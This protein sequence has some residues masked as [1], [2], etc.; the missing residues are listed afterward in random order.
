MSENIETVSSKN[1]LELQEPE[2][3][4][5]NGTS[6]AV[7]P[8]KLIDQVVG[9]E[10]AVEIIRKAAAQKRNVLLVGQPGTGK[11]MIAQAMAEILPLSSLK[12][13]LIYPNDADP[14]NPKVRI[15][16]AGEGKKLLKKQ[17]LRPQPKKTI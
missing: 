14:N 4:N 17:G 1:S 13:V 2:L 9:Q 16:N 7:V 15:V 6:D 8:K 12:D 3:S 10:K 5:I 11:S